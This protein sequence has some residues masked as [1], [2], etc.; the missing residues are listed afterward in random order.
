MAHPLTFHWFLPTN[1]GDGRHVIG[2]GHGVAAG[3]SDR[4]ASVP[5]LGQIVPS[6]SMRRHPGHGFTYCV[7]TRA[8]DRELLIHGEVLHAV[9]H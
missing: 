7:H 8:A 1:G 3:A 4:P 6:Q 5:Y 2:G 9:L